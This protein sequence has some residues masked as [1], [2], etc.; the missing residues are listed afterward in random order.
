MNAVTPD[1][2]PGE[3]FAAG[4]HRNGSGRPFLNEA[5]PVYTC[6]LRP[7]NAYI[8]GHSGL[9]NGSSVDFRRNGFH[10][11]KSPQMAELLLWARRVFDVPHPGP[12]VLESYPGRGTGHRLARPGDPGT[13]PVWMARANRLLGC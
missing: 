4:G 12:S 11:L 9:G 3:R 6:L 7:V 5:W 10:M 2:L 8:G 13:C 1:I